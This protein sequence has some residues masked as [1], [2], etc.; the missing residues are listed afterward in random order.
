M[1]SVRSANPVTSFLH[2]VTA[3]SRLGAFLLAVAMLLSFAIVPSHNFTTHFRSPEVRRSVLRHTSVSPTHA[4]VRL[5]PS[6]RRTEPVAAMQARP[7]TPH[8]EGVVEVA[9]RD[10]IVEPLHRLKLGPHSD[11]D[12]EPHL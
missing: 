3:L 6:P 12:P 10:S 7:R 1:V 8:T 4:Q 2:L 11:T 9:T 5:D